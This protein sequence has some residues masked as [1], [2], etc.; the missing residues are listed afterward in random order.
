MSKP[1]LSNILRFS[2]RLII[3]LAFVYQFYDMTEDYLRFNYLIE[4]NIKPT[5]YDLPSMT[6]CADK[7]HDLTPETTR[8]FNQTFYCFAA[9]AKL[10]Y[11]PCVLDLPI[12]LRFKRNLVCLTFFNGLDERKISG[13]VKGVG[14]YLALFKSALI[15]AN[16]HNDPSHF[17]RANVFKA[18]YNSDTNMKIKKTIHSYL[19]SPYSTDCRDYSSTLAN[20]VWPKSQTDCKLEYMRLK[21]LDICGHNYYWIQYEF[22]KNRI[23]D[24]GE[25]HDKCKI[26]INEQILNK[27]CKVNC[28]QTEYQIGHYENYDER[29]GPFL[30]ISFKRKH[31]YSIS[32]LPKLNLI[33]YFSQLGGLLSMYYGYCVFH[34]VISTT[35]IAE[36]M[37]EKIILGINSTKNYFT[38]I[39]KS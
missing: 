14:L 22:K 36:K 12:Y 16:Q 13:D 29:S 28:E 25:N 10:E 33:N 39:L 34:L 35:F 9:N 5:I 32:Y 31:Y 24:F 11:V 15:I 38:C 23:L 1:N 18:V 4:L 26:K 21:E 30:L 8:Y 37:F 6:V 7:S 19:P 17:E 27:L 20:N 3:F 2:I